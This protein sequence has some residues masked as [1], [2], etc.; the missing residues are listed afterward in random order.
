M[1]IDATGEPV[2]PAAVVRIDVDHRGHIT[3]YLVARE[4][5][6]RPESGH[7]YGHAGKLLGDLQALRARDSPTEGSLITR[8]ER[9]ARTVEAQPNLEAA[10]GFA[11]LAGENGLVRVTSVRPN[12]QPGN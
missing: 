4:G 2:S 6:M 10:I 5:F 11:D 1:L 8:V 9:H 3:T 7:L 12:S